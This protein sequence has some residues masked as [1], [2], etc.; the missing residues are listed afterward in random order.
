MSALCDKRTSSRSFDQ[1][2]PRPANGSSPVFGDP[3]LYPFCDAL[4]RVRRAE[5][6]ELLGDVGGRLKPRGRALIFRQEGQAVLDHVISEDPAVRILCGFRWIET[7][8]VRKRA[9]LV[10]RGDRLLSAL[11]TGVPHQAH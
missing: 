8:H 2:W 10:D 7:Y 5:I 1:R 3:H 6:W 9:L 4:F 11:L